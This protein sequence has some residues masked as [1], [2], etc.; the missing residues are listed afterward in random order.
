MRWR[1]GA[2][3]RWCVHRWLEY[4]FSATAMVAFL[5][6]MIGVRIERDVAVLCVLCATTML[7]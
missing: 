2:L 7:F 1:V 3:V 5:G 6:L 4:F